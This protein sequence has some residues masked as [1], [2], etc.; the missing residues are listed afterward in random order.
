MKADLECLPC[1]MKQAFTTGR[2]AT[3][4]PQQ[5]LEILRRAAAWIQQADMALTPAGISKRVYEIVTDVT[6]N[7]DPY[8]EV[9]AATN[10]EALQLVP[11]LRALL[12]QAPDPL[13][14][15]LHMAVAGNIIDLGAGHAFDIRTDIHRVMASP[16]AI[17]DTPALRR[18]LRP[19]R[20]LLFLGDNSGE[21]IFDALLVEH[22]LRYG[23]DITFVVKSGPI[24]NDATMEDARAAGLPNLVQVMESGSDDIGINFATISTDM[25]REFDRSDVVLA[26]GHGNFESCDSAP[27]NFYFLLKAKCPVVARALNVAEGSVVLC[28]QPNR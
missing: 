28:H 22:L 26:K 3:T 8:H 19:G 7:D 14:T 12:D 16:F 4:D 2:H 17:D 10:R 5:R 18:E 27:Y 21:I 25:R 20:K 15:A 24:I 11:D 13:A 6:G 9:K 23:L 1:L